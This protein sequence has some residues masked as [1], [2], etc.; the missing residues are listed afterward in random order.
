MLTLTEL[1]Y[2]LKETLQ[3]MYTID[4]IIP[5]REDA[6]VEVTEGMTVADLAAQFEIPNASEVPAKNAQFDILGP[7]HVIT[8]EDEAIVFSYKLQGA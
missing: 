1:H 3:V 5:N 4:V 6:E 8:P 2:Q 7:S